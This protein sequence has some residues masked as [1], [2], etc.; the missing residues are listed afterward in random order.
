MNIGGT[1]IPEAVLQGTP[2]FSLAVPSDATVLS[3][4]RGV[5][6][7]AAGTLSL[8]NDADTTVAVIAV[9]GTVIPIS[10]AKILAAST[11]TYILLY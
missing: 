10:P 2:T 4:I 5:Y 11:G 3:N 1:I 7:A 9:A 8:K 6:V